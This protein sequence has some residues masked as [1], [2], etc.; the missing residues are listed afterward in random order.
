MNINMLKSAPATSLAP[1][2]ARSKQVGRLGG[3]GRNG[4]R[5]PQPD[6]DF[7]FLFFFVSGFLSEDLSSSDQG[8]HS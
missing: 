6:Q 5:V 4:R 3:T 2:R 1:A 7:K 8:L